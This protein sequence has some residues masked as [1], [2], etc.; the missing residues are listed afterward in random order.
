M[1][2]K[3]AKRKKPAKAKRI[4]PTKKPREKE[5]YKHSVKMLAIKCCGKYADL[6]SKEFYMLKEYLIMS[7]VKI[8]YRTFLSLLFFSTILAFAITF[9]AT[10]IFAIVARLG[11]MLF[12]MGIFVMPL[13]ISSLTFLLIFAYPM[14]VAESKKRDIEANLPFAMTHMSA[15][16]ESGAPPLTIFR[17]LAQFKEYGEIS[18]EAEKI[19]RNVKEFGLDELSAIRDRATKS[20]SPVL[21]SIFQGMLSTIQTGGDIRSYLKDEAGKTMFDYTLK[22]EKYNEVLSTYAD[23]YTALLVAAPMIFIVVISTL[24]VIGGSVM[25]LSLETTM[26]LGLGSL[27][28]LN[29]IF[30][31]FIQLT[32]PKM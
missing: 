30:L 27:I 15:I 10:F 18:K 19:T 14:S 5:D 29:M 4:R 9:A 12:L 13:F 24:S 6:Y 25:G 22:R 17:I 3:S 7:D 31:A 21:R 32:Q 11:I 16:A 26:T 23:L 2:K 8:L 28:V 20:P 1:P